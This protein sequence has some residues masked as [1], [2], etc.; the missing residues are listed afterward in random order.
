M[1]GDPTGPW[2]RRFAWCPVWTGNYG[3][4]WLCFVERRLIQKHHYLVGGSD[5]WWQYRR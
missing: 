3:W 5:W 4:K 2:H 1:F